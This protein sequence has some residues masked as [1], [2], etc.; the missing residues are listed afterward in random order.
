[1]TLASRF[2]HLPVVFKNPRPETTIHK[3]SAIELL[4][5]HFPRHSARCRAKK[6]R[7]KEMSRRTSAETEDVERRVESA[8]RVSHAAV[9]EAKAAESEVKA[10]KSE[11]NAANTEMHV[12]KSKIEEAR[13]EKDLALSEIESAIRDAENL[14]SK[15]TQSAH[16]LGDLA[17]DLGD[18]ADVYE[19]KRARLEDL[20]ESEFES[21]YRDAAQKKTALN[22]KRTALETE[23]ALC[24]ARHAEVTGSTAVSNFEDAKEKHTN[25]ISTYYNTVD[26]N[27]TSVDKYVNAV[28]KYKT[29]ADNV[30][31][32]GT[33]ENGI[34][35]A[36]TLTILVETWSHKRERE[37]FENSL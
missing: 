19:S 13:L 18:L 9:C 12:A 22:K 15:L 36:C 11:M 25:S 10:A 16:D 27:T 21:F 30:A 3:L 8:R 34:V 17:H 28:D 32:A 24:E 1:V 23:F 20:T 26:K 14:E 37:I 6:S 31:R 2:F 33:R 4:R 35:N 7:A 5:S 29:A